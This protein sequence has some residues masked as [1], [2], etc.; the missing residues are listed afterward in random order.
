MYQSYHFIMYFSFVFCFFPHS[1]LQGV[2]DQ[3]PISTSSPAPGVQAFFAPAQR[4]AY[5]D[6]E[7]E[8]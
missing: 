6:T 4:A 3:P 7:K 1:V 2:M 5:D 8:A